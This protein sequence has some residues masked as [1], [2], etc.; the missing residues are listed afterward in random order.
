MWVIMCFL[1]LKSNNLRH[2]WFSKIAI[3]YVVKFVR[4]HLRNIYKMI[5]GGSAL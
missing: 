5:L 1:S 2:T 3:I 4:R